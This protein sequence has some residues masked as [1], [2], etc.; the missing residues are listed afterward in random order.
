MDT[1]QEKTIIR[2]HRHTMSEAERRAFEQLQA[3]DPDL[4][5]EVRLYGLALEAIRTEGTTQLRQRL[6]QKGTE[7][8]A[9]R[10]RR[11]RL[12]LG[13]LLV[14]LVG[15][16]VVAWQMREPPQ[17]APAPATDEVVPPAAL[18][19]EPQPEALPN[20]PATESPVAVS[21][22]QVFADF[23]RPYRDDSLEPTIRGASDPTPEEQ[24]LQYYWDGAYRQAAAAFGALEPASKSNENIRFLYANCLLQ[25]ER[26]REATAI[27][28]AVAR[29]NST[30]FRAHTHW[31]LGLGL[32]AEGRR[33][34]AVRAFT[35]VA[36]TPGSPKRNDARRVLR[37]LQ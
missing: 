25:L 17:K 15:V 9:K 18:P 16:A 1:T 3:N 13:L 24:F 7:M 22:E 14:L 5:H 11:M 31:Y 32:L 12:S 2:Y 37:L 30:R 26:S 10:K 8:D 21:E 27:L 34:A 19:A 33:A 29:R 35:Q 6:R 4:A 23:F 20:V 36:N 28:A